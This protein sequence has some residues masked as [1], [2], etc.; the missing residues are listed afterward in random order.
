M[1]LSFLWII[2]AGISWGLDGLLRSK[3]TGVSPLTIV[4]VEH[5]IGFVVLAVVGMK[6][7]SFP[8]LKTKAWLALI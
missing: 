1:N 7:F 5:A 3:I 8:K 4:T 6:H 2:F